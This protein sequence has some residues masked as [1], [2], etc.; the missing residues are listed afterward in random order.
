MGASSVCHLF[1]ASCGISTDF[2]LTK[3]TSSQSARK[4]DVSTDA[5]KTRTFEHKHTYPRAAHLRAHTHSLTHMFTA[6]LTL[7]HTASTPVDLWHSHQA[8]S[9]K[10]S[11]H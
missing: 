10:I 7:S 1:V 9:H 3:P 4:H 8:G 6:T 2:F 11:R 5:V